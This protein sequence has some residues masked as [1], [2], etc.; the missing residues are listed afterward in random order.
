MAD[1]ARSDIKKANVDFNKPGARK[2]YTE[3]IGKYKASPDKQVQDQVGSA[4]MRLAYATARDKDWEGARKIFKE[5]AAQYKGTDVV[6]AS[7][8]GIKDQALYQ[9]AVCLSAEGKKAEAAP[10]LFNLSRPSP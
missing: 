8:G 7:F 9:A 5:A 3:F 2:A 4:R 10:S 1:V 6:S